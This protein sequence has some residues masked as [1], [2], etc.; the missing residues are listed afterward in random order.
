MELPPFLL[1]H[2]IAAHEFAS[3]P[4]PLTSP[5]STGP[6]W[7]S[8]EVL[9]L[10]GGHA[11]R[12]I[13]VSRSA[14]R[15]PTAAAP[16][17]RQSLHS[18]T[19]IRTGSSSRPAPPR[20]FR[21]CFASPHTRRQRRLPSPAFPA[22]ETMANAWGIGGQPLT[23]TP[24]DR[25]CA[26]RRAGAGTQR[27]GNT[28]RS[29]WSTRRRESHGFSDGPRPESRHWQP[30]LEA[31]AIPLIV[32]E[33][34]HPLYFGAETAP[35]SGVPNTIVVGDMSKALSLP[36]CAW[37]GSSMPTRSAANGSS[38]RAATSPSRLADTRGDRGRALRNRGGILS[39][40]SGGLRQPCLA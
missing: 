34:Y 7:T 36:V 35:A 14:M 4:I 30:P 18:P 33:V 26:D 6:R 28:W 12:R 25:L 9:A 20:V 22:F 24:R 3:P 40:C 8:S 38:T 19:S 39:G 16:C 2:W 31:R 17:A 13:A 5:S 11:L 10:D 1:D 32:D 21:C 37:A 23:L 15:R 29:P 27:Q